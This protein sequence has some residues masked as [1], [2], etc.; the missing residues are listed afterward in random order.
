[1]PSRRRRRMASMRWA[2]AGRSFPTITNNN[3]DSTT[4]PLTA[5][6][7]RMILLLLLL[8]LCCCLFELQHSVVVVDAWIL[9]EQQVQFRG[10]AATQRPKQPISLLLSYDTSRI[11]RL[12]QKRRRKILRLLQLPSPP[13]LLLINHD[14]QYLD[15]SYLLHTLPFVPHQRRRIKGYPLDSKS[16]MNLVFT[17]R[18]IRN[19]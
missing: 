4:T 14:N 18:F 13:P 19:T 17:R 9:V 2:A 12:R 11:G 8:E 3:T 16:S 10:A 15:H 6:I 1:M 5:K 7:G